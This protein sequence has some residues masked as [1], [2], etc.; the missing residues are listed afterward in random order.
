MALNSDK[1]SIEKIKEL[2]KQ[3]M[4]ITDNPEN[5]DEIVLVKETISGKLY[6]YEVGVGKAWKHSP[7]NYELVG[8]V[9][10]ESR[11]QF[12]NG[13]IKIER[14][15]A[16]NIVVTCGIAKKGLFELID[17]AALGFSGEKWDG[18]LE[19]FVNL[20]EKWN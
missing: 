10:E 14:K 8:Y 7:Q 9:F 13:N 6:A 15:I 19:C 18:S 20:L 12:L 3:K 17:K 5:Q 4:Q 2:I 11:H 1:N 16:K